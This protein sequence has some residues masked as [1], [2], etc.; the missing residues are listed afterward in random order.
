MAVRHMKKLSL[1]A[2][3]SD[4]DALMKSLMQLS[5]VDVRCEKET[6]IPAV[7][8][9]ADYAEEHATCARELADVEKARAILLKNGFAKKGLFTPL[10]A[11]SFEKLTAPDTELTSARQVAAE[12]LQTAEALTQTETQLTQT[13]DQ[14]ALLSAWETDDLP[15]EQT[16]SAATVCI[17]GRFPIT[18]SEAEPQCT[19][20]KERLPAYVESIYSS[21]TGRCVCVYYV[22]EAK[23]P[24]FRILAQHDFRYADFPK[25]TGTVSE[26]LQ[27]LRQQQLQIGQAL[28]R[29]RDTLQTLAKQGDL[30]EWLADV[31]ATRVAAFEAKATLQCSASTIQLQ[32]W[33]PEGTQ[34][35][36]EQALRPYCC[37]YEFS[38]PPDG[39]D[40]PVLLANA[41]IVKPF[42]SVVKLYALPAYGT[43]DPTAVMSVFYFLIFGLMFGDFLYGLLLT[44]FGTLI[45]KKTHAGKGIKQLAALFA[46]CG[47]SCMISGVIFGSYFG[48][49]PKMVLSQM[50]GVTISSPAL[51]FDLVEQPMSFLYVAL[52]VGVVHLCYGMGIQFW[53]LWKQGKRWDA[54]FDIGGWYLV[55][56]G[57]AWTVLMPTVGKW[58]LLGSALLLVLTQGR[59]AK[60]PVAKL[61][62]G[63]LSLYGIVNYVSD[64]LSY[65]RI[66]ALGLASAIIASVVNTL[67]TLPGQTVLGYILCPI[68]LLVGHLVNLAINLLGTFVHT[69]R[70]QYIEFFG[71][72]Y[73]DGG[74]EFTPLTPKTQY[75]EYQGISET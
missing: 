45:V 17:R 56:I 10:Q 53:I 2:M 37:Y 31:L 16:E 50:F 24:V 25:L 40:P 18:V 32:A 7:A 57:I 30:L 35:K 65:S 51:W 75:T 60:S 63:L 59:E 72:F 11:V 39:S 38:D 22:R 47:I 19:F 61:L 8:P 41:K 6:D 15:L 36:I 23:D 52:G 68:I 26:N 5:C 64:L 71:K 12:I 43:Y 74:R 62:K 66:M 33:V 13:K 28:Q 58:V 20:E 49:M 55:F 69:S 1:V 3:K 44:V 34:S 21:S 67:A 54:V 48:D 27:Y 9:C 29:L 4:A 42:E 14:M 46:I 70:L 73:V